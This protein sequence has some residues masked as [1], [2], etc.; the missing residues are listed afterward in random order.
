MLRPKPFK[1]L[2]KALRRLGMKSAIKEYGDW[3]DRE[4][5]VQKALAKLLA[6]NS[7]TEVADATQSAIG[8]FKAAIASRKAL[9][10]ALR[11]TRIGKHRITKKQFMKARK[12]IKGN[13][14]LRKKF[15]SQLAAT[16]GKKPPKSARFGDMLAPPK[17]LLK[18]EKKQLRQLQRS[19]P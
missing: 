8:A 15:R 12:K 1:K 19:V 2:S 3:F 9:V 11:S 16:K 6:A 17:T 5:D 10:R 7:D 18:G 13:R 4:A 14:R